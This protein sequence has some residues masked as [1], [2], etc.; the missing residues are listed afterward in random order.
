[1]TFP[2]FL[3]IHFEFLGEVLHVLEVEKFPV[4][5]QYPVQKH[6][7]SEA[8]QGEL[9]DFAEIAAILAQ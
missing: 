1:M 6:Q 9:G 5:V 8:Y 4:R 2:L 7:Q 3:Q